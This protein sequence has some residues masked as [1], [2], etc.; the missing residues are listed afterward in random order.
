LAKNQALAD[1][2]KEKF[3]VANVA[4]VNNKMNVTLVNTGNL[5][6]NFTK[7]WIQNTTTATTDWDNSYVPTKGFVAPGSTLTNLGQTIPAYLNSAN[8]YNV[9]LVTSRG[10]TQSLTINS[11]SSTPLNIQLYAFPSTV[12]SGFTSQVV[13]VVTNNSTGTLV[14]LSPTASVSPSSNPLCNIGSI[15]PTKYSTLQPGGT[16]IFVW[17]LT[18]TGNNNQIC[19]VTAQLQNGQTIS[20]TVTIT[21][22]SL[23]NTP[24]AQNAGLITI[25]YTSFRWTQGT[26]WNNGWSIPANTNTAFS[27]QFTNNNQTTGP[28]GQ[29]YNLWISQYS[30]IILTSTEGNSGS[31]HDPYVFYIVKP[32]TINPYTLTAYNPEYSTGIPN[33]GGSA[34]LYFAACSQGTASNTCSWNTNN[35]LPSGQYYGIFVL[36]GKFT[37]NSGDNTVGTYAQTI[38]FFA[39]IVH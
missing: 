33:Q 36:Y 34:V 11:V 29:Q 9:K 39:V 37:I 19:T 7:I 35:N 4:V 16:A 14:N 23:N 24:Y 22:V 12:P 17:S 38:P 25:S 20:T 31:I 10:N 1:V 30:Q 15:S 21:A 8:S 32:V 27:I 26:A 5:P 28:Q 6:I 13:L 2:N 3:Q 18:A